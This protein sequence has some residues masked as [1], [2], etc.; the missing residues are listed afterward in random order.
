MHHLLRAF[1]IV[2]LC[3][4]CLSAAQ[5]KAKDGNISVAVPDESRFVEVDAVPPLSVTWIST[6]ETIRL[7]VAEIPIRPNMKLIRSSVEEG[8]AEEMRGKIVASSTRQQ[9]GHEVFLMTGHGRVLETEVYITQAVVAV[10]DKVYKVMATGLGKDTRTDSDATTFMSSFKILA[11]KRAVTPHASQSVPG[12]PPAS[13]D[14]PKSVVDLLS[15]KI[16]GISAL[17]L[18]VCVIAA[19]ISRFAKRRKPSDS[20]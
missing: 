11:T 6:D 4:T 16:G 9:D 14:S 20:A 17:I 18:I 5:W 15:Q 13:G 3:A 10:G 19:L 1:T 8:L 2:C 7:G 12:S